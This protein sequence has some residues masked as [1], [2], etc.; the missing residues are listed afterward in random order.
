MEVNGLQIMT[1]TKKKLFFDLL[2][3]LTYILYIL[4]KL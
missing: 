3:K 4:N 1:L 2:T